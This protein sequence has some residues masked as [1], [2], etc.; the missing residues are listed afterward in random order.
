MPLNERPTLR[1]TL[2]FL[3]MKTSTTLTI[4]GV[5]QTLIGCVAMFGASAMAEMALAESYVGDAN[6][7][8]LATNMHVGVGHAFFMIGIL[9]LASRKAGIDVAK[10]ILIAYLIGIA[11]MFVVMNMVLGQSELMNF[12]IEMIAPD[13][14]FFVL[15]IYGYFK[16]K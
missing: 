5:Y 13:M 4:L 16:A 8:H 9:L 7:V 1:Q 6:L 2:T 3:F 10:T 11:A 15:A 12:S 14:V